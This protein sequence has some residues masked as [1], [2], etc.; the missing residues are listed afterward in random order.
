MTTRVHVEPIQARPTEPTRRRGVL[1]VNPYSSGMTS[2]RERTIVRALR[3]HLDV[4]VR[5]TERPGHAT[6]MAAALTDR[7]EHDVVIACGG[8]GTANEVLNGLALG[9]DTAGERPDFA[10]IPA[11]G[12][13]V[14]ARSVGHPNHPVKALKVLID[15]IVAGRTRTI[16]LGTMDE[17]TYM[18]SAGVG[19]D[20][21]LIKRMDARRSGRRPSDLAHL[22]Q[23][24]G[25]YASSRFSF[26]DTMTVH[27]EGSTT[28]DLRAAFV[29]V[30][31]TTPMTYV[32]NFAMH[33]MPE[34]S[35]EGGLDFVAPQRANAAFAIRN[36]M[37]SLG[38]DRAKRRLVSDEKLQLHHDV[39]GFTVT[40]EE[41]TAV[42]ADGEYLGDRTHI[43][44]GL[45]RNAVN[46]VV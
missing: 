33:M 39:A 40:C 1:I 26:T 38:F 10:I 16:N 18:F 11:G 46:L 23:I 15:G 31:N 7:S 29:L 8:D 27:V 43:T 25:L 6:R 20:G 12:T 4:E 9:N 44:F 21:E 5:R 3:E 32:G 42:Q 36:A 24:L 37:Q 41:P 30:G 13:N 2:A 14:L 19:L 28:P 35:L 45:L 34:A 17:R 22:T